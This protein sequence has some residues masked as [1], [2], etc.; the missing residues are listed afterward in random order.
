[1]KLPKDDKNYHW[2]SHIKS[3]MLFYKISEQKIKSILKSPDRHEEGIASNTF[4]VMKRNDTSKR[5][6]ELWVM[7]QEKL[8]N[9]NEKGKIMIS[10]WRYP[11]KSKPGTAIPIPE[12]ILVEIQKEWF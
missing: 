2:T 9:K 3:K 4:A 8:K 10:A 12:D 1:M 7:Y 6:E 5:K 11:G